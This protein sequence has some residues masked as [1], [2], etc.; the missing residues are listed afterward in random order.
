MYVYYELVFKGKKPKQII[1]IHQI[2]INVKGQG[3]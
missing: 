1:N 2:E 3:I